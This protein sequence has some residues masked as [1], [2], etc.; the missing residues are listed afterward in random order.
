MEFFIYF[1]DFYIIYLIKLCVTFFSFH[2][3]NMFLW[4]KN[5]LS[6]A[7][8]AAQCFFLFFCFGICLFLCVCELELTILCELT[9]ECLFFLTQG[10]QD[11]WHPNFWV[12]LKFCELV[13]MLL[14]IIPL[15]WQLSLNLWGVIQ[16]LFHQLIVFQ[17]FIGICIL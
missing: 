8:L 2:V 7:E 16:S 4:R 10:Y 15:Q 14:I 12:F 17:K 9:T 3:L 11:T 5:L 13:G 1:V 6:L